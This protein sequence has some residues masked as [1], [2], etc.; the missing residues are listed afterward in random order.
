MAAGGGS[1]GL[2]ARAILVCLGGSSVVLK[3][4]GNWGEE[5]RQRS[6]DCSVAVDEVPVDSAV[7]G[8]SGVVGWVAAALVMVHVAQVA[9]V[10]LVKGRSQCMQTGGHVTF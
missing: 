8:A 4:G 2:V 5:R 10:V 6:Q 7:L 9:G 1:R 3:C